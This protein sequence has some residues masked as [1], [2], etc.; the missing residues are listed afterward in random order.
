[1][2]TNKQ[3]N[4]RNR[5]LTMIKELARWEPVSVEQGQEEL[6]ALNLINDLNLDSIQLLD[7]LMQ[8]EEE[9]GVELDS[10]DVD[11]D[12]M[13]RVSNLINFVCDESEMINEP[14]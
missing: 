8:I 2:S 13:M 6:M 10:A 7:F 11:L 9:F 1:M 14:S 5:I 3:I 12:E 4:T